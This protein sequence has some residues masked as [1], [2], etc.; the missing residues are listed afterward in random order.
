VLQPSLSR[1][2]NNAQIVTVSLSEQQSDDYH[3]KKRRSEKPGDDC[4][5][6]ASFRDR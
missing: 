4:D 6:G 1:L 3:D 5:H 2:Q